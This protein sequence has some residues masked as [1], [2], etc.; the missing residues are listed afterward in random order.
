MLMICIYDT[1]C[2]ISLG[3]R[4][5]SAQSQS[6]FLSLLCHRLAEDDGASSTAIWTAAK[7]QEYSKNQLPERISEWGAN[8]MKAVNLSKRT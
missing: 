4:R 1:F 2:K 3:R 6:C 5:T 7:G 8:L